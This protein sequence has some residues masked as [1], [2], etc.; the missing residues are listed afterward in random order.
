MVHPTR[1]DGGAYAV[2]LARAAGHQVIADA[3]PA[4]TNLVTEL[5]ASV[6]VDCGP[7]VVERIRAAI[8]GGSDACLRRRCGHRRR[9]ASGDPGRWTDADRLDLLR[10]LIGDGP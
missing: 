9:A 5:G 10:Q 6:A 8:P 1:T 7:G 4:D 3:C 2:Q